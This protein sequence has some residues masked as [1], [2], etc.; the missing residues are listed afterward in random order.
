[1]MGMSLKV[2]RRTKCVPLVAAAA[3]SSPSLASRPTGLL[4]CDV[5]EGGRGERECYVLTSKK[6]F[7]VPINPG[8]ACV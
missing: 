8:K 1:M 7:T 5:R 4:E 6:G 3:V 2:H